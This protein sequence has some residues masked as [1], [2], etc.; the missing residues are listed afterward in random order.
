MPRSGGHHAGRS[1]RRLFRDVA[2]SASGGA[3]AEPL[4][5]GDLL[6]AGT[7]CAGEDAVLW[8][9]FTSGA[10]RP[11]SLLGS[12]AY[13]SAGVHQHPP[14]SSGRHFHGRFERCAGDEECRRPSDSARPSPDRAAG[15][16]VFVRRPHQLEQLCPRSGL[17]RSDGRTW[18]PGGAAGGSRGAECPRGGPAA[19]RYE[20]D[21]DD[22]A[23]RGDGAGGDAR[24]PAAECPGAG[25]AFGGRLVE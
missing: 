6:H 23:Q 17:S 7:A 16:G 2:A 18:T 11:G 19:A 1:L 4:R 3:E 25:N 8:C 12:A 10:Q 15:R 9:D 13:D 14:A 21:C 22:S 24:A 20:S 5:A